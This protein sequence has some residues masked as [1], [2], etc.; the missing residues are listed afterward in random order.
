MIEDVKR[1][2]Y[3]VSNFVESASISLVI[4]G[5]KQKTLL[6]QRKNLNVIYRSE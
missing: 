3:G 2:P 1:I 4:Y 5:E 6:L